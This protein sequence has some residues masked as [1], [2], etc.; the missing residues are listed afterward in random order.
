MNRIGIDIT[1]WLAL[2]LAAHQHQRFHF[3]PGFP[4]TIHEPPPV[5]CNSHG[6]CK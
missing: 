2:L 6:I 1:I 5:V 3:S 4:G